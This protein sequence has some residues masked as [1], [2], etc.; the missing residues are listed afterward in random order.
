[1]SNIR[2]ASLPDDS[3]MSHDHSNYNCYWLFIFMLKIVF[4]NLGIAKKIF[5]EL[6]LEFFF[7]PRLFTFNM[8]WHRMA[9]SMLSVDCIGLWSCLV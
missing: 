5:W 6:T 3:P 2:V 8:Q 9:S 4:K 1:M 7:L